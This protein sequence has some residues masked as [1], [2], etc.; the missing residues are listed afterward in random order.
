MRHELFA[1][2]WA[3]PLIDQRGETELIEYGP[4]PSTYHRQLQR[5]R[6]WSWRP[7]PQ[8]ATTD[9]ADV[10][11][12]MREAGG[13]QKAPRRE[14]EVYMLVYE[15]GRSVRWSAKALG[16]T[17]ESARSYLRRLRGRVRRWRKGQ[18]EQEAA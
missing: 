10:V 4:Q 1:A 3:E 17:R 6:L 18:D 5:Y 13:L 16:I 12:Y 15:R 7:E 14:R 2:P 8:S 9:A 11:A